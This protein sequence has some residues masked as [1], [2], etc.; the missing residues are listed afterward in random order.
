MLGTVLP[1]R[2]T[3]QRGASP[4][5]PVRRRRQQSRMLVFFEESLRKPAIL[6]AVSYIAAFVS[7]RQVGT[8]LG[9]GV[10]VLHTPDWANTKSQQ[11]ANPESAFDQ[12]GKNRVGPCR[13][14]RI[15]RGALGYWGWGRPGQMRAGS[16]LNRVEA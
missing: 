2:P 3:G 12:H 6:R 8:R 14:N 1:L 11:F 4:A 5:D 15:A 10:L 13:R 9:S 16:G 7:E